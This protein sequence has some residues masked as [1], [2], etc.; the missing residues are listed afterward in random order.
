MFSERQ[1]KHA[2]TY[3]GQLKK[4]PRIG[5]ALT[6]YNL[7]SCHLKRSGL[8]K[9]NLSNIFHNLCLT[10]KWFLHIQKYL[11]RRKHLFPKHW[12]SISV[13]LIFTNPGFP[14]GYNLCHGETHLKPI[15]WLKWPHLPYSTSR[16]N[17][18]LG[19]SFIYKKIDKNIS[20][21]DAL[22]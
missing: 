1:L 13:C 6:P 17:N 8:T 15:S 2:A 14:P 22:V 5:S 11:S 4:L 19:E 10:S 12:I 3:L 21:V 9:K 7:L 20:D 16:S 18:S